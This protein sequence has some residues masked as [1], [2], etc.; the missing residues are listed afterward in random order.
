MSVEE[1]LGYL[2]ATVETIKHKV[3]HIE[4]N[5]VTRKEF[6]NTAAEHNEFRAGL[7]SLQSSYDKGY[8]WRKVGER[9]LYVAVGVAVTGVAAA[10]GLG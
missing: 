9:V 4:T 6:D 10:I 5:M 2:C 7:S 8:L 1:K 3:D